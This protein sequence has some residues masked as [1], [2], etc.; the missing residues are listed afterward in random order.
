M[1]N[2]TVQDIRR[3]DACY[4]PTTINGITEETSMTLLE[5]LAVRGVPAADKVWLASHFIPERMAREFAIWCA[6][7]IKT[8]RKEVDAY[9]D[10]IE[11]YYLH[12][13]HTK[14]QMDAARKVA[15]RAAYG[16]ADRAAF[17]AAFWA[18]CRAAD[19]A[20]YWAAYWSA[21]WAAYW[22][23]AEAAERKAQ[24]RKIRTMLR[25]AQQ[26]GDKR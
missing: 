18:A 19:G 9:I 13:T 24:L 23:A 5:W 2:I 17:W 4:D 21:D 7:R 8:D 20:A 25:R 11:G 12:G 6:R 15:D 3:K 1:K 14:A 22:A 10:V 26:K 16:A